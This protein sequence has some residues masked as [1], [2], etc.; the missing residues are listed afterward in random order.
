[1]FSVASYR[2]YFDSTRGSRSLDEE[3]GEDTDP[4]GQRVR[5]SRTGRPIMALIDLLGRRSGHCA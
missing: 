3:D 2:Y 5:G 1:M 4:Q